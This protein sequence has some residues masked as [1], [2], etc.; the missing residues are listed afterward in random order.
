MQLAWERCKADA[1]LALPGG[2]NALHVALLADAAHE[3]L[4]RLVAAGVPL[5]AGVTLA[6]DLQACLASLRLR[7]VAR[8]LARVGPGGTPLMLAAVL[9]R[10]SAVSLLLAAGVAADSENSEAATALSLLCQLRE[11]DTM[12]N[13]LPGGTKVS[14]AGQERACCCCR[15]CQQA[16]W[17]SWR[18]WRRTRCRRGCEQEVCRAL[19]SVLAWLQLMYKRGRRYCGTRMDVTGRRSDSPSRGEHNVNACHA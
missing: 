15:R 13:S 12:F 8:D 7:S 4:Q 16:W 3:R 5:G 18:G 14:P 1:S 9:G 6:G 17:G 10:A 19:Q 2:L 11:Q